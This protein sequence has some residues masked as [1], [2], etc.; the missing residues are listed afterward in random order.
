MTRF[1]EM[2][3]DEQVERIDHSTKEALR[4]KEEIKASKTTEA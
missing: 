3:M 1:K 2:S 4:S